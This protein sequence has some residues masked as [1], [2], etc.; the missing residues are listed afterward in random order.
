MATAAVTYT[1]S[2]GTNADATKVN[3]NFTDL[4]SFINAELI[5]K[6]ASV[7]FTAVPSGP[8]SN[9]TTDNQLVRKKYVDD[10]VGFS[11][12]TEL[13]LRRVA[14]QTVADTAGTVSF[15]WDTE[16]SDA[17][18]L[19]S[20]GTITIATAGLYICG[21]IF[22]AASVAASHSFS[23]GVVGST[24]QLSGASAGGSASGTS[25]FGGIGYLT[26]GQTLTAQ[27][28]Y[29]NDGGSADSANFT[30]QFWLKKVMD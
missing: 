30:G 4:V 15:V 13:K 27:V 11:A 17:D 10:L 5:Q 1:F 22:T 8:A 12:A 7:A 21:G 26:A 16:D 28:Q 23:F 29:S 24:G 14:V 2:N 18:G 6:D 25:Y 3:T 19:H 20:G 9:P